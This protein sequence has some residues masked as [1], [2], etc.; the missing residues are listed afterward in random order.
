MHWFVAP[1]RRVLMAEVSN[2]YRTILFSPFVPFIVL[3]CQVIE[4]RDQTDLTRLQA[5]VSS[6][7]R[8]EN[9]L[10]SSEP[11][12]EAVTKLRKLFQ[13]LCHV[14]QHYID[15]QKTGNPSDSGVDGTSHWQ[16]QTATGNDIDSY[17]ATLGFPAQSVP[18]QQQQQQPPQHGEEPG[19]VNPMLWMGSGTQLEDWFYSNQQ[20]MD[21]LEDGALG[22]FQA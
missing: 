18:D 17:L 8:P 6:I 20:M 10:T 7:I 9:T 21:F 22:N 3:F 5:F 4:T 2:H 16:P 11:E 1:S 12:T 19:G 13:V 15:A 14:A